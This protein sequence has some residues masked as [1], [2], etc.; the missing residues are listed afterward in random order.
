MGGAIRSEPRVSI[1]MPVYNGERLLR[2]AID[3]ILA[4]TFADF[5]L[6]ISDNASTDATPEICRGYAARDARIQYVAHAM[7][8]G[9]AWN[10]QRLV[11]LARAPYFTWAHADDVRAPRH[12]E[13][14]IEEFE[15][16][17]PS[18]VLVCTQGLIVDE[19]GQPRSIRQDSMDLRQPLASDRLRQAIQNAG[20]C[21]V[22][23]GLIR[24]HVL[25]ACRPLGGYP[26]ADVALV[27]ELAIRGQFWEIPEDLFYRGWH[28]PWTNDLTAHYM[29]PQTEGTLVLPQWQVFLNTLRA[30]R[31]ADLPWSEAL[32]CR[33]VLLHEWLPPKWRVMRNELK[34]AARTW[35]RRFRT[36][37]GIA[38]SQRRSRRFSMPRGA[39]SR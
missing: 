1:G 36:K 13:R 21:N 35:L 25:R 15:R 28:P 30:I 23:F 10:H 11:E 38:S 7:N 33:A 39:N 5:E 19:Q 31:A 27:H 37:D 26:H 34:H 32:R 16:A 4:Q 3:S 29:D 17:P 20:W 18:V 6:I 22:I 12:L 8:R 2:Q 9:A 14:C 24:T